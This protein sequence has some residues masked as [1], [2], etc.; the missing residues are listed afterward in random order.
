M[1]TIKTIEGNEHEVY[2]DGRKI[3]TLY[4][5]KDVYLYEFQQLIKLQKD[6]K[7]VAK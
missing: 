5:E 2:L 4:T 3:A 6:Y 7:E 1:I